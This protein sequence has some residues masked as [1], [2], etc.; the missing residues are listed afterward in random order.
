M[1]TLLVPARDQIIL[2]D[3]VG[4]EWTLEADAGTTIRIESEDEVF[5]GDKALKAEAGRSW[6][7]DFAAA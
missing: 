1:E 2:G 6:R 7:L 5:A 4:V 3:D